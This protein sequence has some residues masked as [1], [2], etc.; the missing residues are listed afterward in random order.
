MRQTSLP[1]IFT[2]AGIAVFLLLAVPQ[3]L[4]AE[5]DPF[6]LLAE[7]LPPYSYVEGG[8]TRGVAVDVVLELFLRAGMAIA[9]EDIRFEP[10]ARVL[11][12]I[13][14]RPGSVAICVA[15]TPEREK[16]FKWVGPVCSNRGGLIALR[17]RN[18]HIGRLPE[19][20][21][22]MSIGIVR[23]S[24]ARERLLV[25]GVPP[26]SIFSV[27]S[28]ESLIRM[29]NRERIDLLASD[30]RSSFH[31]MER[32]GYGSEDFELVFPFALLDFHL[33]FHVGTDDALIARLQRILD[34]MKKPGEDGTSVYEQILS[35]Y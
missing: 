29:L 30:M 32:L 13:E 8:Q 10:W 4:R 12:N 28:Q 31:E 14:T 33:A 24:A 20:V 22:G 5:D 17:K 7:Q 11:Q 16:R 19:D 35:R 27:N 9:P 18:F 1:S 2:L 6:L 26:D 23:G 25:R 34:D 15:R 3:N 21:R